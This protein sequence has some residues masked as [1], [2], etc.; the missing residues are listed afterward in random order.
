MGH[1]IL[2]CGHDV[3]NRVTTLESGTVFCGICDLQDRC[4][5]AEGQE[6]ELLA[7]REANREALL[8]IEEEVNSLADF[9][10]DSLELRIG[11]TDLVDRLNEICHG[12]TGRRQRKE[13]LK[14]KP[15]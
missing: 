4:R 6:R 7:E 15:A 2:P 5:D 3:S 10:A 1:E 9:A 14:C 13:G 12:S 11:E 8:G